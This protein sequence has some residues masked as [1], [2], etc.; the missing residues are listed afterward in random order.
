MGDGGGDKVK[1]RNVLSNEKDGDVEEGCI[2]KRKTEINVYLKRKRGRSERRIRIGKDL[3]KKR[4]DK[5]IG[6]EEE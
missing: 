3:E 6:R 2:K 5:V 1:R 4:K